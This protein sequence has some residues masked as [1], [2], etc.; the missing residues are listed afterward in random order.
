MIRCNACGYTAEYTEPICPSCHKKYLFNAT[1]IKAKED[2]IAKAF[3]DHEF[4]L[5]VEGHRILADMGHTPSER[6]YATILEK[7][8][9]VSRD[10]DGAMKYFFSAAEKNDAYSAYR[11]ARLAERSSEQVAR[12]WLSYSAI[13]GCIQAY[14]HLAE[15]LSKEGDEV[16]ANYYYA[17]AAACDDTDS[18]VT[19]AKRY[20]KGIGT[21]KN[22]AYA[23][24][25]MDKLV[26]PPIHAIR[27]A[28]SLRSVTAIEPSMP[29]LLDYNRI[30]AKLAIKA[31]DGGFYTAYHYL[32]NILSERGDLEARSSLASLY[33]DGVGCKQDVKQAIDL[34]TSSAA[35]GN[36]KAYKKLGDVFLLGKHVERNIAFAIECYKNSAESGIAEAYEIVGDIYREGELIQRD[37]IEAISYYDLASGEGRQSAK[38]KADSLRHKREELF[39]EANRLLDADSQEAFK[40]YVISAGMGYTPSYLATALCYENGIGTSIDRA[41]AF[42]WYKKAVEAKEEEAYYYLGLCYSRGIGTRHDF[43]LAEKYLKLA[44]SIN[45]DAVTELKR[46][47]SSKVK[48]LSQKAY[49]R[50]MRLLYMKK[51]SE[52]PSELAICLKVKHAK[53]IYTLACLYEFG[54]GVVTDRDMAYKLYELAFSLKYRDPRAVY[55]LKVLRMAKESRKR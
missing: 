45:P 38:E 24:W 27:L 20:H 21:E 2:E 30:I 33:L 46:L 7:G 15:R 1:E 42:E 40:R 14:P 28:Y 39:L 10:L 3:A 29:V 4:E 53:G 35:H 52:V 37:Y 31:K 23:K 5:Y 47:Y 25:Y 41:T 32:L 22:D 44:G 17:L 8:A 11:F 50:A 36:A 19:L 48:A 55:K 16:T 54:L 26:L 49:S 13:L 6:E 18:I 43:Y 51:Y 9:L 34:L 12:F